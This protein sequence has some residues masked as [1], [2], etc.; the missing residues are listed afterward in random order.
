M[1]FLSWCR[2]HDGLGYSDSTLEIFPLLIIG[3]SF[4]VYN[5]ELKGK[6]IHDTHRGDIS[7]IQNSHG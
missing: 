2:G 7:L 6:L 4:K 1:N 3:G 5:E